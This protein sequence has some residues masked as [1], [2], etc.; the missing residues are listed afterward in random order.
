MVTKNL[1]TPK[2]TKMYYPRLKKWSYLLKKMK[3]QR[4]NLSRFQV[5]RRRSNPT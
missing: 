5:L 3:A 2:A 1:L 4:A